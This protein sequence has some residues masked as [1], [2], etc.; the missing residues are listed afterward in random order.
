[1]FLRMYKLDPSPNRQALLEVAK[2]YL[3][4]ALTYLP[5]PATAWGFHDSEDG[6][7]AIEAVL[8]SILGDKARSE[9]AIQRVQARIDA[10]PDSGYGGDT[11]LPG[12]SGVL[13]T[14]MYLNEFFKSE[15][16]TRASLLRVADLV[17]ADGAK[18]GGGK[19]LAYT[20]TPWGSD[21]TY[22]AGAGA[23]GVM[24]LLLAMPEVVSNPKYRTL[25]K[26]TLDQFVSIQYV[27]W[28]R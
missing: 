28:R 22:G 15:V 4:A 6:V 14:G 1:M 3:D 17:I 9:A 20:N 19:Y 10:I 5:A 13:Y 27:R 7:R 2:A 18:L 21:I 16:I 11:F 8:Y 12:I 26:N 25:L 24:R 23:G